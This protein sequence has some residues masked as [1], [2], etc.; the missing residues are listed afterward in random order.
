MLKPFTT[1]VLYSPRPLWQCNS[2]QRSFCPCCHHTTSHHGMLCSMSPASAS[3]SCCCSSCC[4]TAGTTCIVT[5]VAAVALAQQ[6]WVQL[7]LVR[8]QLRLLCLSIYVVPTIMTTH[9]CA[10]KAMTNNYGHSTTH[11]KGKL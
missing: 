10:N 8:Q 2:I 7:S 3:G 6:Q 5:V 1:T 11:R 9:G 4:F